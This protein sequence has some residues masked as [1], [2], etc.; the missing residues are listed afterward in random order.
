[1]CCYDGVYVDRNTADVL[2]QISQARAVEFQ[3]SGLTLPS[4]VITEAVW[5]DGSSG[6]KTETKP[7]DFRSKVEGFPNHFDDTSCVFHADDGR[8]TLQTLGLKDN[9]HPWFYKP[10]TCWLHP[11]HISP[12][13]ITIFNENT[14]LPLYRLR[15]FCN[16]DFLWSYDAAWPPCI[17]VASARVGIPRTHF[18]KDFTSQFSSEAGICVTTIG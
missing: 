1:M 17:R 16:P 10:L 6:L 9:K 4:T 2:Q 5:R 7:T 18:G 14:D 15:R 13:R 3:E 11:I 12:D 8:C